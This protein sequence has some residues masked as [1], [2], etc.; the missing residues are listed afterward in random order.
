MFLCLQF[1]RINETDN[2]QFD[3]D[4]K[5]AETIKYELDKLGEMRYHTINNDKTKFLVNG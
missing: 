3:V 1:P 4:D 5:Q 2:T